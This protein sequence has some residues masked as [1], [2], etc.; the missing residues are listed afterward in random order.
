METLLRWTLALLQPLTLVWLLLGIW[1]VHMVWKRLW[2]WSA[3][4]VMA[5]VILSLLTCTPLISWLLLGLEN[6]YP[7]PDPAAVEEADAIVC[8]GGGIG[9]SLTEPTGLRLVRGAD[10]LSTALSMAASG[11][12]PVLVLGGGGY[13]QDE[14]VY[15]EADAIL[16]FLERFPNVPFESISLGVCAHTRDEAL[17]VAQ[18]AQERGWDKVL[19]VTSA[20]HMSRSVGAFAK[21]GV[22]V[23]PVPCHY[24]SRYN[25]IGDVEWLHLPD[26]T[27][28]DL[29]DTWFHE[30][31]GTWVYQW[32]GW[33]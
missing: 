6:R 22:T 14:V 21:A 8:L 25:Q 7:L 10:R 9:P 15:S 31:I 1:T 33:M 18:L 28:F 16:N 29:F 4:P 30:V 27:S 2:R 5:W 12:A 13:K 23:V 11:M 20:S 3:L 19:L 17:K 32:R 26:R 24:L